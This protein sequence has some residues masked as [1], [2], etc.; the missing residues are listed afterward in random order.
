MPTPKKG[1]EKADFIARCHRAL[2]REGITDSK[3][4]SGKCFG[5]WKHSKGGK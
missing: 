3:H 2:R 4:R 5:I 1:E